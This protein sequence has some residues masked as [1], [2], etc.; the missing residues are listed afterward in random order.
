MALLTL[1]AAGSG[2]LLSWFAHRRQDVSA[3]VEDLDRVRQ[4]LNQ[5]NERRGIE[6]EQLRKRLENEMLK[7]VTLEEKLEIAS[8]IVERLR[9]RVEE[10]EAELQKLRHLRSNV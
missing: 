3:V 2:L 9:R 4:A 8:Q 7:R 5:E 1:V 6:I 10:L